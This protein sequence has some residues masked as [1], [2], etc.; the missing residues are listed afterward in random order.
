MVKSS[1]AEGGAGRIQS[2]DGGYPI[3][4]KCVHTSLL[5]RR[6][7]SRPVTRRLDAS[8][9]GRL[10]PFRYIFNGRLAPFRYIFN[11]RLRQIAV[12]KQHESQ[13]QHD[14]RIEQAIDTGP[15]QIVRGHL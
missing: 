3:V 13:Q 15:P 2:D 9:T 4:E 5:K 10:A 11:G 8:A 14:R 1:V 12:L 7:A 6:G